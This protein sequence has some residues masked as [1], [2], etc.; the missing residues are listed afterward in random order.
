MSGDNEIATVYVVCDC[1][2]YFLSRPPYPLPQNFLLN[3]VL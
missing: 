2:G 1:P 3:S